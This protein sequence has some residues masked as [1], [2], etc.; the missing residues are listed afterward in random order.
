ML[1]RSSSGGGGEDG[2]SPHAQRGQRTVV[3]IEQDESVLRKRLEKIEKEKKQAKQQAEM[4]LL[5]G[6]NWVRDLP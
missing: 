5:G 6:S 1:L 4:E 3:Q 2:G